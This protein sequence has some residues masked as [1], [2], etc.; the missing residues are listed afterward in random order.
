MSVPALEITN[1]VKHFGRTKAV[2]DVSFR[3]D[4]GEVFG[5]LG[6]NGAGKTTT[7]RCLMDFYRPSSGSVKVFGYD[8]KGQGVAARAHI[9][10]MPQ[11]TSL[12]D[13]WTGR[14]HIAYVGALHHTKNQADELAQ[15][16]ELDL[17]RRVKHLSTG[18]KQKLALVLAFMHDADLTILDEPTTGLDPILQQVVYK[19]IREARDRGRTVFMSSHNLAEV[20]RTCTRVAILREGKLVATEPMTALRDKHL[21]TVSLEFG[22]D[23]T[24][25]DIANVIVVSKVNHSLTLKALG[26]LNPLLK[27]L[28]SAPVHDIQIQHS[29]LEE[30]FMEFYV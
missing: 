16:F 15:E 29:T 25:P 13:R 4:P 8:A 18:N 27:A 10:F 30:L 23:Y 1:L 3:V 24:L 14:E 28:A 9:G 2:D 17:G 19:H 20:E 6:P 7:I 11:S 12:N 5:F 21:Y 26:D 22:Q